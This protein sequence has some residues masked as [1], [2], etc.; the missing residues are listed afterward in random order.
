MRFFAVI[1]MCFS[2]FGCLGSPEGVEPVKGFELDRYLG[3]WYEIARLDHSFERGMDFVTAEYSLREDGGVRVMNSGRSGGLGETSEA[4][5]RA[6]F[7]E[8]EGTGYL[9]VSFFGPFFGSY[10]IF[11]LDDDYQ[12]AFVAGNNTEYLWLLA[13]TPQVTDEV[14][15]RFLSQSSALGFDTQSLIYVEQPVGLPKEQ[16]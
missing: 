14:M 15:E 11:D 5:G 2:L 12:H 16:P 3:R 13:R 7:V 4:E 8:D 10:V 6:Y 1:A 9:K